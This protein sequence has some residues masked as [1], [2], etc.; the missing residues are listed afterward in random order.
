LRAKTQDEKLINQI[1]EE[2]VEEIFTY[3]ESR[4]SIRL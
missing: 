3:P 1:L 2:L 4:R